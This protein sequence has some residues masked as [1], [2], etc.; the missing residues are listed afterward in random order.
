MKFVKSCYRYYIAY[1]ENDSRTYKSLR[2]RSWFDI[3]SDVQG[4][5]SMFLNF[6][7]NS[8]SCSYKLVVIK[9]KG[10]YLTNRNCSFLVG[11]FCFSSGNE[12]LEER[13]SVDHA[14]S[15]M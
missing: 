4:V 12:S 10:F 15:S 2:K 7:Q 1:S 11:I 6:N 14:P 13:D 3:Q 9:K 8:A 5:L